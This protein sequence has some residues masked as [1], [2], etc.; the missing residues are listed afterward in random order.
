MKKLITLI[1][2]AC[3]FFIGGAAP[4]I[5]SEIDFERNQLF[6]ANG[7]N[8][9]LNVIQRAVIENSEDIEI[10]IQLNSGLG[11]DDWNT[12]QQLAAGVEFQYRLQISNFNGTKLQSDLLLSGVDASCVKVRNAK[13]RNVALEKSEKEFLIPASFLEY[14]EQLIIY[15]EA[16]YIGGGEKC[17]SSLII[18]GESENFSEFRIESNDVVLG[19]SG[20]EEVDMIITG[21]YSENV[22]DEN[23]M[24]VP[25]CC[26]EI[27][28]INNFPELN[29]FDNLSVFLPDIFNLAVKSNGWW[30][31]YNGG[32][33]SLM[34]YHLQSSIPITDSVPIKFVDFCLPID[35]VWKTL[36]FYWMKD[37]TV[38]CT[39]SLVLDCGLISS[40]K[41]FSS[42]QKLK[43]FPNPANSLLNIQVSRDMNN[44]NAIIYS[45]DGKRIQATTL[46]FFSRTA[47]LDIGHLANGL[48][49]L[50]LQTDDG[51]T[52]MIKFVKME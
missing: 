11:K 10:E 41:S 46:D 29:A 4:I 8:T 51:E 33:D 36:D 14:G 22:Y 32:N 34:S 20:C 49:I 38:V 12:H 9:Q 7:D 27:E 6:A 28:L 18:S 3:L 21:S 25:G 17:A 24:I 31:T 35:K 1:S 19:R 16:E 47:T 43:V 39:T 42:H 37:E 52:Q 30:F 26:I 15:V 5:A 44:A 23:D 45:S 2:L 50:Q 48:Y 13:I 40:T